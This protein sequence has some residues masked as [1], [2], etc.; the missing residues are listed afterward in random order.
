[1]KNFFHEIFSLLQK[2]NTDPKPQI[3]VNKSDTSRPSKTTHVIITRSNITWKSLTPL[4]SFTSIDLETTGL[5]PQ[6]DK[7]IEISAVKYQN[8]TIAET[9]ETFINPLIS[10]PPNIT[11]I[12]GITDNMVRKAPL[13][14][15][16]LPKFIRFIGDST[17]VGH[18]I[19]FDLN[20][21]EANARKLG[22]ALNL[23]YIDT[24]P[25]A[26]KYFP[27]CSNHKLPTLVNYLGINVAEHHRALPDC[28]SCA[29]IYMKCC[30][31]ST[32][33]KLQY[34]NMFTEKEIKAYEI[35]KN[36]L[37]KSNKNIDYLRFSRTGTY[38]DI[39]FFYKLIRLKLQGKK[40]YIVS[41][42]SIE[43]LR[44]LLSYDFQHENSPKSEN[45]KVRILLDNIEELEY[46]EKIILESYDKTIK[47]INSYRVYVAKADAN[48]AEYLS[49]EHQ[50]DIV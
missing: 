32:E 46:W 43:N 11:K 12:N 41:E 19:T 1:M 35:I 17:L 47:S 27:E 48:I 50:L 49:S 34:L 16:V 22:L 42:H 33:K 31:I 44:N 25:L 26:R 7:I 13:I 39:N 10:I 15:E 36:L 14:S 24:L 38:L 40:Q 18:N 30:T 8:G 20:F 45:G 3:S 2:R 4:S 23:F 9:F 6:V 28:I 37:V 5:N 29:E 21:I